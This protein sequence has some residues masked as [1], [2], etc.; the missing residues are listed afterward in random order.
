[1][2][3]SQYA[4]KIQYQV[5]KI[6][7]DLTKLPLCVEVEKVVCNEENLICLGNTVNGED[8]SVHSQAIR[9]HNSSYGFGSSSLPIL[10]TTKNMG[11]AICE[12]V[13][14]PKQ[15]IDENECNVI[16]R[17]SVENVKQNAIFRTKELLAKLE[18][19][20]VTRNMVTIE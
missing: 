7:S 12:Y 18:D 16:S 11:A 1:M 10:P 3:Q 8:A 20:V 9:M 15:N 13:P 14:F 6:E 2:D 4:I 19:L 17:P 5:K